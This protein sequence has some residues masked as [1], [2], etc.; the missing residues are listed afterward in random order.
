MIKLTVEIQETSTKIK[1]E[2]GLELA[3]YRDLKKRPS[4]TSEQLLIYVADREPKALDYNDQW[5]KQTIKEAD[6]VIAIT[7]PWDVEGIELAQVMLQ[8]WQDNQLAVKNLFDT[9]KIA[10]NH[11]PTLTN[12]QTELFAIFATFGMVNEKQKKKPMKAQHRWNKQVSEIPFY[13][14]YSDSKGE[15]FWQKRNEMLLKA[16]AKLK[17]ELPLNKDGS[18]GFSARLTEKLRADYSDKIV[19]G[20]TTEDIILKS[21]NEVGLFLYFAGTNG[22]LVLKDQTGKTIDEYTV[23]K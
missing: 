4:M 10:A 11:F 16:G 3:L 13:I 23:V 18:I 19:N 14:D 1:T 12:S 5:D 7:I 22:W 6:Q 17:T 15:V 20:V 9:P 8:A 21:V 2:D